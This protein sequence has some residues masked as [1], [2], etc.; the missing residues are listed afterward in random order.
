MERNSAKLIKI[1]KQYFYSENIVQCKI[2]I[3]FPLV[4]VP[5]TRGATAPK[6]FTIVQ[7]IPEM[8]PAKLGARKRLLK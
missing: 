6:T 8:V 2:G 5:T 1:Y 4:S 3:T 7:S